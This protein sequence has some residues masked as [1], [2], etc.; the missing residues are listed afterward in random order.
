MS[1]IVPTKK[2][3]EA[4]KCCKMCLNF[5]YELQLCKHYEELP[6]EGSRK[7][8]TEC[9]SFY[10]R[11]NTDDLKVLAE[12]IDE[13]EGGIV[14]QKIKSVVDKILTGYEDKFKVMV[15]GIARR[16][17][18]SMVKMVDIVDVLLNKLSN[19]E[20]ATINNMSPAQTIRLLSELNN[21][22]NNDLEFIMKLLNPDTQLKDLQI[23]ID[24]RSV[25]N[26]NGSSDA[27]EM[28]ADEILKLTGHSREKIREA[29]SAVLGAIEVPGTDDV[30]TPS[31]ED[32]EYLEDLGKGGIEDENT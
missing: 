11:T 15:I 26:H 19:V 3:P 9:A 17:I 13:D 12:F 22:V 10:D 29:F 21:S 28:K 7:D 32:S 2:P 8:V 27:T 1:D 4:P 14:E 5:D 6:G 18:K 31:E 20:D 25:I 16:K 24:N 30:H 23:L